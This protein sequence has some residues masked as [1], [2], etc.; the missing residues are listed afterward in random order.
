MLAAVAMLAAVVALGVLHAM[1]APLPPDHVARLSLPT[2]ADVVG[3]LVVTPVPAVVRTRLLLDVERVD[4]ERRSG[5]L[6][7]TAYGDGLE[8]VA[9]QRIRAAAARLAVP[10]G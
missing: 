9:G 1:P 2:R 10:I 4:D 3:R 6:Q 7:L 5:R 8:L